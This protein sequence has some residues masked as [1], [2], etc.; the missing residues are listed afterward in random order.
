[1]CCI[2]L[3]Q[4]ELQRDGGRE[5]LEVQK[6]TKQMKELDLEEKESKPGN[7]GDLQTSPK[8]L[9]FMVIYIIHCGR[10][11]FLCL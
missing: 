10:Q 2:I 7:Q 5:L 8:R 4:R 11:V 6:S 9:W 1:M 3:L